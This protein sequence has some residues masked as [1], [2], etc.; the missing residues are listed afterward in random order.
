[1]SAAICGAPD[2]EAGALVVVLRHLRGERAV[3]HV[4]QR[5]A[6]EVDEYDDDE[7][8]LRRC[9]PQAPVGEQQ[10]ADDRVGHGDGEEERAPSP[11]FAAHAVRPH[12]HERLEHGVPQR[13]D[14]DHR[15]GEHRPKPHDV[16]HEVQKQSVVERPDEAVGPLVAAVAELDPQ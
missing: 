14:G 16:G 9:R 2:V 6:G 15:A 12:A 8:E 10:P 1:M 4:E 7:V 13:P 3:R 11:P 5:V